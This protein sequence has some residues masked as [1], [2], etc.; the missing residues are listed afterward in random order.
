LGCLR[1][2]SF[3]SSKY[4]FIAAFVTCLRDFGPLIT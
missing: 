2:Y 3:R 4:L 1:K